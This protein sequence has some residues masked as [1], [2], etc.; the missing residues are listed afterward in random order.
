MR[1]GGDIRFR[2]VPSD[3]FTPL[4]HFV[5][6]P[7]QGGRWGARGGLVSISPLEGEMPDR[8]EGGIVRP[9]QPAPSFS[10]ARHILPAGE[11]RE[12]TGCDRIC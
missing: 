12:Q 2:T 7:P 6:Y 10:A 1:G 3:G 5:T 11:K 9:N 8:A 4:C